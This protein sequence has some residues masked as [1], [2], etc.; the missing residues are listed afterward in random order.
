V[1]C[2][3]VRGATSALKAVTA[4]A[5]GCTRTKEIYGEGSL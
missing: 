3:R 5:R 2:G 1:R 4:R